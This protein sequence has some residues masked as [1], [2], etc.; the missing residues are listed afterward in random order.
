MP[1]P[2]DYIALHRALVDR[3]EDMHDQKADMADV[4]DVLEAGRLEVLA[5]GR[6][7]VRSHASRDMRRKEKRLV[8]RVDK[9]LRTYAHQ[10]RRQGGKEDGFAD[11]IEQAIGE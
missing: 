4:L 5:A 9:M 3:I 6:L 8:E 2:D 11:L 10:L 1:P 7:A